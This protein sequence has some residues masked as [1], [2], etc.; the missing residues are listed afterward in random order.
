LEILAKIYLNSKTRD[1]I[2]NIRIG[3]REDMDDIIKISAIYNE[4]GTFHP[5]D[6][7]LYEVIQKFNQHH[8]IFMGF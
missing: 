4:D 6:F 2:K 1:F 5:F 8:S 3:A 7:V